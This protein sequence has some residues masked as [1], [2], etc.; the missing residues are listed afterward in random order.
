MEH[1]IIVRDKNGCG[2]TPLTAV[3]VNYPKLFTP[4]G[5]S[6][7]DTW[8]VSGISQLKNVKLYIYNR[9]G[10]LLTQLNS[11]NESWDGTINNTPLP[12]DDYWFTIS[13]T[14]NGNSKEFK[15]HF[16]LKR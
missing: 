16:S 13:Y 6:Y 9:Y 14:E 1:T 8:M 3:V 5:D 11:K 12:A 15:S 4:N 10:K 2:S 7:S